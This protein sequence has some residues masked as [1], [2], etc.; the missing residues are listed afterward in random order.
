MLWAW[1]CVRVCC[2][3]RGF[4]KHS[5]VG[6]KNRWEEPSTNLM[7]AYKHSSVLEGVAWSPGIKTETHLEKL[8]YIWKWFRLLGTERQNG[9]VLDF[10][11]NPL[12]QVN[13]FQ[14]I[15]TTAFLQLYCKK[16]KI[17]KK[18][19]LIYCI[20]MVQPSAFMTAASLWGV[21]LGT[22]LYV[23]LFPHTACLRPS[24][25]L[26]SLKFQNF[27]HGEKQKKNR[28]A[29]KAAGWALF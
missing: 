10:R 8:P 13:P 4:V 27:N 14:F 17:N 16:N 23:H 22:W 12:N 3:W 18:V 6:Q 29:I 2:E 9:S 21:N 15:P 1:V 19:S 7:P 25:K 24:G 5:H 28:G 20:S 26:L 11:C